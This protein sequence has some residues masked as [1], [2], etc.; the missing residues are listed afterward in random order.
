MAKY[1]IHMIIHMII[2]RWTHRLG[3]PLFTSMDSGLTTVT[4]MRHTQGDTMPMAMVTLTPTS[5][6]NKVRMSS[7]L[8]FKWK[9]FFSLRIWLHQTWL[10]LQLPVR[11]RCPPPWPRSAPCWSPR[12][13]WSWGWTSWRWS[14]SSWSSP[15][16]SWGCFTWSSP[17][18][19]RTSW[20]SSPWSSPPTSWIWCR[21]WS[22]SALCGE[23]I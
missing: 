17:S 6:T 19:S 12:S 15:S 16:W 10:W 23:W 18:W 11:P 20:S 5:I 22:S 21:L 7:I 14:C 4:A 9:W 13:S 2:F 8:Q 3:A 1:K